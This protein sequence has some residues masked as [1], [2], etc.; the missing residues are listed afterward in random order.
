MCVH[1]FKFCLIFIIE[2]IYLNFRQRHTALSR[3]SKYHMTRSHIVVG[4]GLT[5]S[6]PSVLLRCQHADVRHWLVVLAASCARFAPIGSSSQV[7][8]QCLLFCWGSPRC[9][10]TRPDTKFRG[11][12]SLPGVVQHLPVAAA[13]PSKEGEITI[14]IWFYQCFGA[15][16]VAFCENTESRTVWALSV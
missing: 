15:A 11:C 2:H 14:L 10:Q 8:Q 9:P 1:S 6:L 5:Y 7:P 12:S 3:A 16:G 13:A 4:W